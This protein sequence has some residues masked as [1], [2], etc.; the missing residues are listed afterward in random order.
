MWKRMPEHLGKKQTERMYLLEESAY[1]YPL[2]FPLK[3]YWKQQF[4]HT[5]LSPS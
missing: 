1:V 5:S 4:V 2:S 3:T